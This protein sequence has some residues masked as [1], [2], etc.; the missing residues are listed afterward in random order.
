VESQTF[1]SARTETFFSLLPFIVLAEGCHG[2]D[3][4]RP[5]RLWHASV[6]S[7]LVQAGERV[8]GVLAK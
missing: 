1:L 4:A 5:E 6:Q 7:L 3:L 2:F 8:A